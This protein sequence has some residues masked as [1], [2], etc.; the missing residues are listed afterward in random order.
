MRPWVLP[1]A[2]QKKK[3]LTQVYLTPLSS[4]FSS[5]SRLLTW[6]LQFCCLSLP[7]VGITGLC[8][9]VCLSYITFIY[10]FILYPSQW[11]GSLSFNVADCEKV[12]WTQIY[13]FKYSFLHSTKI[14]WW[15]CTKYW[16][17]WFHTQRSS[18]S[19]ACGHMAPLFPS[20]IWR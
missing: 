18:R 8:H 5:Y 4:H 19:D 12:L 14:Y 9:H 6:N 15:H 11:Q 20:A 13:L 3:V 2:L 17:G 1:P 16:V 7:S 10:L